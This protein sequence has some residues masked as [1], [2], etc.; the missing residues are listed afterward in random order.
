MKLT[1]AHTWYGPNPCS[2][3]PVL[4]ARVSLQPGQSIA[5]DAE[6]RLQACFP[7]WDLL[8]QMPSNIMPLQRLT[9]AVARWALAALNEVRGCLYSAGVWAQ[10]NSD[11]SQAQLFLAWHHP[12]VSWQALELGSRLALQVAQNGSVDR[13]ALQPTLEQFWKLCRRHHPDYQA[14]ILMQGARAMQVPVL[15]LWDSAAFW[16]FGWGERSRVMME[17]SSNEDGG[18]GLGIT[19]SK[20]ASKEFFRVLGAPA[21][22]HV[23]VADAAALADAA[24]AIGFPCVVKP[25]DRGG[26]K[27]VSAGVQNMEQLLAAYQHARSFTAGDIMVEQFVA[28][29]DHRL[30]VVEGKLLVAVC[31]EPSSV[32]GDGRRTLGELVAEKNAARSAHNLVGSRYL[33]PI[34]LDAPALVH[35][36]AQGMTPGAVPLDGQRVSLRGNANLSTGGVARDVTAQVHPHVRL[37]AEALAR[38]FGLR[39]AGIDYITP[40]ISRSWQDS[41]G[42]FIEVN[43]TPGMEVPIA[44]GWSEEEVGRKILGSTPGRVPV[45]LAVVPDELL[46]AVRSLLTTHSW[47]PGQGWCCDGS[48]QLGG[49]PLQVADMPGWT[50]VNALLRH[51]VLQRATL[52]CGAKQLQLKGLPVDRVESVHIWNADLPAPWLSLLQRNADNVVGC[53]AWTAPAMGRHLDQSLQRRSEQPQ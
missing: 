38:A 26:G 6:Q 49:V 1:H 13:A 48:A 23:L 14:R 52:V 4:L 42:A 31:R 28:G 19:R 47:T 35:L 24:R 22:R 32:I 12:K 44:A 51:R 8:A 39:T 37:M 21:P 5:D 50:D 33:R 10:G 29:T 45:T 40:D 3:E 36:A 7:E 30:M 15:R 16:Q 34:A 27:G 46:P 53:G 43:A 9:H 18:L 17:S 11:R 25:L 2:D 20:S 41:E